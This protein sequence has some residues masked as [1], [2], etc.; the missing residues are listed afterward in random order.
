[1]P[2][3]YVPP[4][5]WVD[6]PEAMEKFVKHVQDTKG[7]AVDTETS[8]L[9]RAK[10][11][12]LFWS[13]C[14]EISSRYCFSRDMLAILNEELYPD[15]TI[16]WYFTNQTFDFDMMENSGV[17]PPKGDCH[18]TLAMDWLVD[19][20][21]QGRH[22]LKE[23]AYDHLGLNMREFKEAFM[24][25]KRGES[26]PERL[27]RAMEEDPDGAKAY[28]SL[29]AWATFRVFHHLKDRLSSMHSMDGMCL[30]DYFCEV[31][32]PF[33]KVLHNCSRRGIMVDVGYLDELSPQLQASMNEIHKKINRVAGKEINLNSTPQMRELLFGKLRLEPIKLTSGGDSGNKQPSTDE[34]CL[35]V[36]AEQGVE[37]CQLMIK[38]R[39]LSKLKGTY[40]DGLRRWADGDLRI[41]PT[42]TQHVTVTGRLSSV[43]PNLQN[44]PRA[45]NDPFGLRGAFIPKDG[46]IFLVADYAQLEMRLLAHFSQ[47]PNMIDVIHKGWDI[48]MGTASLMY[49]YTY[50]EIKA[51]SKRKKSAADDKS[52]VL[53]DLERKMVFARQAAKA[54]TSSPTHLASVWMK[55]SG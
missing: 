49:G 42:L 47:D 51:A 15:P 10:D 9:N 39:E 25:R 37:V 7:C 26:L 16:E 22:G 50:E 29:D 11:S 48:H 5:T 32:R 20:N 53:T 6:T 46:H 8:G 21:R 30:W 1:M 4:V 55:P 14:P 36:W 24:G 28:S 41:H 34:S 17:P 43:D 38:Y 33:T 54:R 31:E 40:I 35:K 13:A 27:K 52:I 45:E 12:V 18:D 44:I 2:T 23:T 19:E 3:Q